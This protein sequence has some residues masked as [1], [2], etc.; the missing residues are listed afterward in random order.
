VYVSLSSCVFLFFCRLFNTLLVS[1]L[2]GA[3][4]CMTMDRKVFGRKRS[5]PNRS[6]IA[7]F[8]WRNW[9]KLRKIKI[10]G[11]PAV[12]RHEPPLAYDKFALLPA[13]SIALRYF[14]FVKIK[15]WWIL[16]S[17]TVITRARILMTCHL[18]FL[19]SYAMPL[20]I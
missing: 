13:C 10:S 3:G 14:A 8:S 4:W 5:W 18:F 2:C 12:N 17:A 9:G 6:T 20:N 19:V 11:V 1:R 15:L 16:V 7:A